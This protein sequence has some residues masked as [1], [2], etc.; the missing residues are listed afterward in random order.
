MS[1]TRQRLGKEA[2]AAA[3]RLLRQKG[4]RILDRNVRVGRGELDIVARVGETLIFVEVKARRTNCY[5]GVAHAVTARK[6]RQ[7]IQLAARYLTR[8]R[9]EGQFC[10]FDVLLYDAGDPVSPILEH[11]EN[12]FE[13]AG[14]DR[15]W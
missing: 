3:E 13:V 7:L 10:R 11:I 1:L 8:H 6:E 5:G 14:D 9:L 4:Y 2:E 15:R 12:A